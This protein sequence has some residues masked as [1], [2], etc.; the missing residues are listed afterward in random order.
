MAFALTNGQQFKGH[1]NTD[2]IHLGKIL[3]ETDLG[4]LSTQVDISG[5][6]QRINAIGQITR[7]DYKGYTYR[8]ITLDG[9]CENGNMSGTLKINDPNL[10]LDAEGSLK[11]QQRSVIR[12]T[13][14]SKN[15]SPKALQLTDK[16][17]EASFAAIVDADFTASSLND[18]EGNI[19][20]NDFYMNVND[21]LH[22]TYHV[23]NLHIQSGYD[24]EGNHY[25]KTNGDMGEA[26]LKGIFDWETLPKSFINYTASKLPTLPG[27]PKDLSSTANNFTAQLKLNETEW[28]RH[29]LGIPLTLH[30]PLHLNI[31]MNDNR[32]LLDIKGQ[33]PAFTYAGGYYRNGNIT[34]T[35]EDNTTKGR[36][37]VS[38][39]MD[40]DE[41]LDLQLILQASDNQLGT[42][43]L[44][45]NKGGSEK[46]I[47]GSL[48]AITEVYTNDQGKA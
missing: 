9:N 30:S 14:I 31:E 17:D 16:W 21:S 18:A 3:N 43:F 40:N 47:R 22:T 29:I 8:N 7:L 33:L 15:I 41:S 34:L 37:M 45:D 42:S 12:F 13:G 4:H 26:V 39:Q 48:N 25:M 11:R 24:D 44:W 10:Q 20:L 38:K 5:T 6:P 1:L 2:S 35:T 23:N 46:E 19:N 28:M 36:I 27:L 32:H